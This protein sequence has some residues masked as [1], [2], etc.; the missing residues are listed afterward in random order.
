MEKVKCPCCQGDQSH[1]WAEEAGFM[2]ERCNE[3]GL[4][5]VNPRPSQSQISEAVATGTH[6][7]SKKLVNVRNR[8]IPS[9][10]KHYRKQLRLILNDVIEAGQPVT[11]VDVG[12]GYGELIEAL[13]EILPEG[14]TIKGVEPMDHKAHE[15]KLRGLDIHH[16]F[17]QPGQ[18]E[19]DFISNIDVF[20]HIPDYHDFLRTVVSN[21]AHQGEFIMETGNLADV[22][23]RKEF[24]VELGLP[25]HLV[26]GGKDQF[27][28][29]FDA[30]GM[31]LI[32]CTE[33]RF[34]TVTQMLK[35]TVKLI[36]GRDSH[37]GIPYTSPYRQLIMRARRPVR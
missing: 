26:F 20:S 10:I 9:K 14:S 8:R 17:L 18:Y 1:F 21:L 13:S 15:A 36:L 19:A 27:R 34:D 6:R 32:S 23:H 11:W 37:I 29:Y 5:Y 30:V 24:P 35:N 33:I 25:D 7:L 12:S 16:G 31:E 2:V 28:R 22:K 3:C 4:L